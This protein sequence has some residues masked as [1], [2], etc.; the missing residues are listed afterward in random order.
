MKSKFLIRLVLCCVFAFFVVG[1]ASDSEKA[2]DYS[3]YDFA[4]VT[5]TRE[6]DCDVETLRFLPNGEFRYSCACGN[7]VND[8]DVVE[9][10]TYDDATKTFTLNCYEEVDDMIT[11]IKLVSC[12]GEKLKLDFDG[13]IREFTVE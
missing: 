9:S 10:Y 6:A 12:D 7:P 11:E 8:A 4:D 1:C 2:V 13:E 3:K 5:W